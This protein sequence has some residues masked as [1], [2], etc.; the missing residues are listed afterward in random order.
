MPHTDPLA[1]R[2]TRLQLAA[3]GDSNPD[4]AVRERRLL[5][6]DRLLLDNEPAIADAVRRDFGH[7]SVAETRSGIS[8]G[9]VAFC[10]GMAVETMICASRQSS[11]VRWRM[12]A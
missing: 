12:V 3:R 5:T 10:L 1:S 9:G 11:P 7:R 8:S 4:R 6:L 2:F